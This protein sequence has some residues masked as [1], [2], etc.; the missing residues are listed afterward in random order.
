RIIEA[1]QFL[2]A[3]R[4][5][6]GVIYSVRNGTEEVR[7]RSQS[8]QSGRP[9]L[10]EP[11]QFFGGHDL[12]GCMWLLFSKYLEYVLSENTNAWHPISSHV[13]RACEASCLSLDLQ[14]LGL[15]VAVEGILASCFKGAAVRD[16]RDNAAI[17]E[18]QSH[19]APWTGMDG[20]VGNDRLKERMS[21][22][23]GMLGG[24]SAKERLNA[25]GASGEIEPSEI[26]AWSKLRN[27]SVHPEQH[28]PSATQ[29]VLNL[30]GS[31]TT[32]MNKLVF[33]AIGYNGKYNDYG[34]PGWPAK[35]F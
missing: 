6:W 1:L 8:K 4:F 32:L 20:W 16:D 28:D 17:Q 9:R 31:V 2:L 26:K 29:E 23:L 34:V 22:L 19:L 27:A 33:K 25:L 18:L 3:E 10:R 13:Y 7:L 5:Q 30:I 12:T 21:G 24:V 15:S 11:I 14:R 35:D